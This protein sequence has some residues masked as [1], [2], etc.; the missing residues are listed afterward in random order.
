[1]VSQFFLAHGTGGIDLVTQNKERNLGE[2][3][4]REQGIELGFRLGKTLEIGAVDKEDD[5]V[6]FREVV[7]PEPTSWGSSLNHTLTSNR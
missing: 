3:F 6:D 7:A 5:S 1:M 4:N 2:F